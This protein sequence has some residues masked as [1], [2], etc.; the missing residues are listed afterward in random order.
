[1]CSLINNTQN[2]QWDLGHGSA[3]PCLNS[4][5]EFRTVLPSMGTLDCH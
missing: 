1:M 3:E 5:Q 4:V 2:T